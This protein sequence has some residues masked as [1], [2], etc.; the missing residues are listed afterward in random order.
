MNAE[1]IKINVGLKVKALRK[2]HNDSQESLADEF[3]VNKE[4]IS[5]I[6]RG[7]RLLTDDIMEGLCKKYNVKPLYFYSFSANKDTPVK[8]DLIESITN[9]LHD[10]SV[11]ALKKLEIIVDVI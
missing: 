6:E 5:R 7:V 10:K 1:E 8:S 3:K 2:A 9:K 11:V 4:K